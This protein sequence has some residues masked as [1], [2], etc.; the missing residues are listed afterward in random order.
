MGSPL[1]LILANLVL[2]ELEDRAIASLLVPPFYY[3]YVDDIIMAAPSL[4]IRHILKVFN[5]FHKR[6][7]FTIEFST[8]NY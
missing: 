4:H 3:R 5:S 7:Q 2:Q 8:N 1:S 6:L